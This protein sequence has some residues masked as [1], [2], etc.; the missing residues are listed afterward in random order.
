LGLVS[1]TCP[2]AA[3]FGDDPPAEI[4][5]V[6]EV[7]DEMPTRYFVKITMDGTVRWLSRLADT[8]GGETWRS[9]MGW[10]PSEGVMDS[11]VRGDPL[12][13]EITEEDARKAL[14]E[15]VAETGR[16]PRSQIDPAVYAEWESL[17]ALRQK[18]WG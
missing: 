3:D 17:V 2:I 9:D 6:E 16:R 4:M 15:A 13:D 7:V 14:P 11:I 12:F 18:I 8:A 10:V 1:D 5:K